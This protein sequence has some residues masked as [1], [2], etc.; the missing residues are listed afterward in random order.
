M[1]IKG[2]IKNLSALHCVTFLNR[3]NDLKLKSP[4]I[5]NFKPLSYGIRAMS[6]SLQMRMLSEVK[7]TSW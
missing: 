7:Y 6:A 5:L 1:F 2:T 4:V 3:A